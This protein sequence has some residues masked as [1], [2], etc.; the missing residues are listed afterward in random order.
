MVIF[1]EIPKPMVNISNFQNG[2]VVYWAKQS[3]KPR[4]K[5]I[6]SFYIV[7]QIHYTS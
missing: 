1:K 3:L 2:L 5:G 6:D 7:I 4:N